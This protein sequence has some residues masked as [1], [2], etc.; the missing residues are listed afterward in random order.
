MSDK[1]RRS[2]DFWSLARLDP[3]DRAHLEAAAEDAVQAEALRRHFQEQFAST[4]ALRVGHGPRNARIPVP[5]TAR[6]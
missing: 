5:R 1:E 2:E 6:D 3:R 4:W